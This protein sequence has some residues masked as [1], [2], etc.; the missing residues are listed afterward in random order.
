MQTKGSYHLLNYMLNAV[1]LKINCISYLYGKLYL[2]CTTK[3]V[4]LGWIWISP[5]YTCFRGV[6][7]S[8]NVSHLSQLPRSTERNQWQRKIEDRVDKKQINLF[9]YSTSTWNICD[10]VLWIIL[11]AFLHKISAKFV[12]WKMWF[13]K[14]NKWKWK[15]SCD[16]RI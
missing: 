1:N 3:T 16:Y 6:L 5:H 9:V 12:K 2:R 15:K 8:C 13:K 7:H 4:G 10:F 11:Y 14:N